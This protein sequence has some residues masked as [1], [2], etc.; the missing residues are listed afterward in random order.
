MFSQ[1]EAVSAGVVQAGQ[2]PYQRPTMGNT[3]LSWC[4]QTKS[5]DEESCGHHDEDSGGG[6]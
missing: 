5:V 6:R 4:I 1:S 3:V 2:V